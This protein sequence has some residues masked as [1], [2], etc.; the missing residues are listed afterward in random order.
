[1]TRAPRDLILAGKGIG[2]IEGVARLVTDRKGMASHLV[3][4]SEKTE[5]IV[6]RLRGRP[7]RRLAV[8]PNRRIDVTQA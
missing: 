3:G 4:I 6:L 2:R 1:M 7:A 8:A 5:T